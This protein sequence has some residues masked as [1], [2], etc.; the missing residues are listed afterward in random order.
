MIERATWQQAVGA[1]T[2]KV[3]LKNL[4]ERIHASTKISALEKGQYIK[5]Q[6]PEMAAD[7]IRMADEALAGMLV[8]PGTGPALHFV[9][10]PPL[11]KENPPND[12]EYTFH[13]NRMHHWKTLSEAYSLTGD[14]RY[15]QKV[16]E[17]LCDWIKENPC[18]P[19]QNP[20][21]SYRPGAFDGLTIWRALEVGIRG[22]RTWPIVLELLI[23]S[24][25]ITEALLEVL[26]PCVW[27]HCRVLYEISPLLWPLADHNHYL[28][29]NL[30]LLSFSCLFP[31]LSGSG[32]FLAHAQ[33]EL[34]RCMEAQCTPCGGQIEGCPSYHNG[35]VFW[36]SL[37]LVLA[38]KYGLSVPLEYT[39]QLKGMF[40]HAVHATRA[41][42]GNFPWGD[43]HI[44]DKE[45]MTLAA[46]SC[47]MAF[48]KREYLGVA[49]H[50]YPTETLLHDLRDNLWRLQDLYALRDDLSW[51]KENPTPPDFGTFAWQRDLSQVFMRSD[52]SRDALS[53]M[54]ACRTPV[55]NLHAH[56]DAGG[57]DFTAFGEPLCSDPGIY[58]YRDCP[59]R[60]Q[61]KGTLWHNCLSIDHKDMWEYIASWKYGPQQAGCILCAEEKDGLSYAISRHHNYRPAVAT[62]L[63]ALVESRY[64][65][66][67]DCVESAAPDS[68]IEIGFHLDRV[69]LSPISGSAV[70][71]CKKGA[72]N[73][74]LLSDGGEDSIAIEEARISPINDVAHP[75][76]IVRYQKRLP[77]GGDYL[78]ATLLLPFGAD[79]PPPTAK[80]PI[81][82]VGA[83]GVSITLQVEGR[84][85]ML[86]WRDQSVDIAPAL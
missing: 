54:T 31:E 33:K 47:Y 29:E 14:L 66:L 86:L 65:L 21:G 20:D 71:T 8:L 45:T 50:F 60:H 5:E 17:E 10:N 1:V 9:G 3:L 77:E 26:I 83:S 82:T 81:V 19:L 6:F 32:Q 55:Q 2:P 67:V 16:T 44:A 22:Y 34:G 61:F 35:C 39:E 38:K 43:S 28:M 48:G 37:R 30:G 64:L 23:D 85:L 53:V 18:P 11:W 41:C 59:E 51:A 15:A 75:S 74:L 76:R 12:N 4:R 56:M 84:R 58:T 36:F 68:L 70:S 73:L 27:L 49:R 78:Q 13:L 69:E 46:V 7:T 79:C 62:R 72:A 40:R 57:F 42:G 52:W 63:L 24:G 80:N 25:F